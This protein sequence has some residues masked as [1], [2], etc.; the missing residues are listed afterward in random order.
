MFSQYF[1]QY[2]LQQGYITSTQLRE[3][4]EM[5]KNTHVR[6]GVIAIDRGDMTALDVEDVHQEQMRRDKK[7]GSLAVEKGYITNDALEAMLNAQKQ[8]HLLLGQSLVD[9]HVL[10]LQEYTDVLD[11][12]KQEHALTDEEFDAFQRGDIDLIIEKMVSLG[13]LKDQGLAHD[14]IALLSRNFIRFVEP[15]LRIENAEV[16]SIADWT[17]TQK[18][19]G[20]ETLYTA[21]CADEATFTQIAAKYAEEDIHGPTELA[22]AAVGELLNLHNGLF[23]VNMSNKG[24][25]LEMEPQ[26]VHHNQALAHTGASTVFHVHL[27]F[28]SCQ[29]VLSEEPLL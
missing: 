19:H 3:A 23:T 15:N 10:T 20:E 16:A 8:P 5:K 2:L 7:F 9:D 21:L 17:V 27:P 22:Q 6:L 28:G 29:I 18:I 11:Q 4:M 14:Y 12:Y 26:L 13:A 24:T 25:E 1:G